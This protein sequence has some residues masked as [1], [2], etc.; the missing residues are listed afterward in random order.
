MPIAVIVADASRARV[1]ATREDP[2]EL[3]ELEDLV[4]PQSR[5]REQEL[6]A[7][8]AGSG[9]DSGGRGMHSMG[10]EKAA[11]DRQAEIFAGEL[12]EEIDKLRQRLKL[13]RIYLVAA[14]AFLGLMRAS[15]GKQCASLV[16]GEVGKNLVTH[17]LQEIRDHLPKRL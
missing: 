6:V 5:L 7:D 10:H 2:G 8:G 16:S 14:P 17:S 4:H 15:L 11:H 12:C 13:R 1:L 3:Y 9:I